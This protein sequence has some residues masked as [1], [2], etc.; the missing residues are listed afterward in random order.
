MCATIVGLPI[1]LGLLQY[2]KFL[3]WPHGNAMISKSDL[4]VITEKERPLWWKIFAWIVQI[5][6]F[7]IG[8]FCAVMGV[9]YGF[10]CLI[11]I[12]GIPEGLVMMKSIGTLFNPVNKVV[13]PSALSHEINRV[14]SLRKYSPSYRANEANVA[15]SQSL[16]QPLMPSVHNTV[17]ISSNS[18]TGGFCNKC[19]CTLPN[20]SSFCPKCG[21][22]VVHYLEENTTVKQ[23]QQQ[24]ELPIE[25]QNDVTKITG[26]TD[27]PPLPK[28]VISEDLSEEK[29]IALPDYSEYIDEEE[30]KK[31]KLLIFG[32]I[33]FAVIAIAITIW[34]IW[35][36]G[37]EENYYFVFADSSELYRSVDDET[38]IDLLAELSYGTPVECSKKDSDNGRWTKVSVKEAGKT[39]HGFV[40]VSTLISNEDF[41]KIDNAGLGDYSIRASV[42]STK[43]RCALLHA[44]GFKDKWWSLDKIDNGNGSSELNGKP[45]LVRGVS[46]SERCFAF[47][48]SNDSAN[49]NRELYVYS[50]TD[51]G[52]PEYLYSERLQ[53]SDGKLRD[54]S[55]KNGKFVTIYT[56]IDPNSWLVQPVDEIFEIPLEEVAAEVSTSEASNQMK[57]YIDGKY[58]IVMEFHEEPDNTLSG[59]YSY[60]KYNVPIAINGSFEIGYNGKKLVKL[61]ESQNDEVIGHFEGVYDGYVFSGWWHSADG[62]K[63]MPFRVTRK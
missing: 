43:Y 53:E 42:S 41:E 36:R 24:P 28:S 58:E 9:I 48:L 44:L 50:F 20:E 23:I 27:V 51:Q 30:D 45:L 11:S 62:Q 34:A 40:D 6:Y 47:V 52:N 37:D 26:T 13:V 18:A 16:A 59:V 54:V 33:G 15:L 4:E 25:D 55:Y 60:T 22:P 5:L 7:P 1:G 49:W 29:N 32:G 2:S 57:G 8:L 39:L 38:G 12:I 35:F 46:P 19:G 14:K 56:K 31:K 63:E 17:A 10:L 61:H 21:S 3:F